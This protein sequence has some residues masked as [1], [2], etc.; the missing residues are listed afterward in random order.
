MITDIVGLRMINTFSK[1]QKFQEDEYF[2]PYH[3]IIDND[4]TWKEYFSYTHYLRTA[5]Q[6]HFKNG[7]S[8]LDAGCGDGRFLYELRT[9][10]LH[11]S[12]IDF[13]K[14]AIAFARI[15]NPDVQ[16]FTEDLATLCFEN[17]FDYIAFIETLEH[18]M[19]DDVNTVVKSLSTA[20]KPGGLLLLTVPSMKLPRAPKHYQHFSPQ[21]LAKILEPYFTIREIKGNKKRS[22]FYKLVLGLQTNRFWEI[23][24]SAA[25]KLIDFLFKRIEF[26]SPEYAERLIVIAE[27]K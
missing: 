22:L 24:I 17:A 8:L 11:C 12:G 6:K 7:Q 25:H 9:L 21:K 27:K 15:F 13:S 14:R 1:N 18:I 20:L 3:Y 2:F 19:P 10:P 4:T 26:C 5:I 23:K 16:F